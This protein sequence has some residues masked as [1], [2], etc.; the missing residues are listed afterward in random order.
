MA[1]RLAIRYDRHQTA[2]AGPDRRWHLSDECCA[3]IDDPVAVMIDAPDACGS[4]GA[5]VAVVGGPLAGLLVLRPLPGARASGT[6][7]GRG[8][9]AG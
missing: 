4:T 6:P 1:G 3:E 5:R 2:D 9:S 8:V 7:L